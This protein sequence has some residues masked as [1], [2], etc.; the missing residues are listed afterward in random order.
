MADE[1]LFAWVTRGKGRLVYHLATRPCRQTA[2]G[3]QPWGFGMR[4]GWRIG[5]KAPDGHV[6]CRNCA[7]AQEDVVHHG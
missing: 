3:A 2:C 4:G 5:P 7:R 6:L 1:A